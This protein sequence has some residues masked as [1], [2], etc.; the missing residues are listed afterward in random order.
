MA[1]R[2]T[3]M[4]NLSFLDLLS[5]AL[6]AVIFLFIITPKGGAPPTKHQQAIVYIDTL[7][8]QVFG[9]LH[10]S[11]THKGVGDTL[12][13]L[14]GDFKKMPSIDDCPA[15]PPPIICPIQRPCPPK[16]ECPKCPKCPEAKGQQPIADTQADP[17]DLPEEP[18]FVPPPTNDYKGDPPGVPCKVSFEIN[19]KDLADNVDLS[20][21]KGGNCVSFGKKEIKDIGA[22]DSGRSRNKLFGNDFRT[23][24][25]AVRQYDGVVPGTYKMFAKYK[26]SKKNNPSVNIS[27]LVYTKNTKG[28]ENGERFQK[29]LNLDAKKEVLIAT[30]EL[31][32]NG[33]FKLTKN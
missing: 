8:N 27:G 1:R 9:G 29:I 23:T 18:A 7:H 20:V 26:E 3:E 24:Q 10:D 22:W 16:K 2:S 4:F 17:I 13:V 19:W 12:L 6:G 25:E 31:K 30:I 14:I 11:L 21:C 28:E 5:G 15:C 32:E 33:E